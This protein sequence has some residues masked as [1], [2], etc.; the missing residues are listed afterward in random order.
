MHRNKLIQLLETY[1]PVDNEEVLYKDQTL[2]FIKNN[3]NCF[4]RSLLEGH[5][6]A[7]A[8]LLTEDYKRALLLHHAK[9]DI[10][11]QVG[12]H[13]DGHSDPLEVAI[14]EAKEES[15][16]PHIIPVFE[17]IFDLDIHQIPQKKSEPMH[18]HYD[19]RFLLRAIGSDSYQK[20]HESKAIQWID[21]DSKT[22]PTQNRSVIRMFEKWKAQQGSL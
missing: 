2:S 8:W 14:K 12:G 1:Q 22:L 19:I 5:I 15:G 9:L 11:V 21:L 3:P 7:S 13:C 20:N 17:T 4:D 18:Y 16:L 10:W 6:T